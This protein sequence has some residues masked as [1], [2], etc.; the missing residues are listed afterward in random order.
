MPLNRDAYGLRFSFS[1]IF[2]FN[3]NSKRCHWSFNFG[4]RRERICKRGKNSENNCAEINF[5]RSYNA[6]CI[7]W[8]LC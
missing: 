4:G 2:M 6:L 1:S 3:L 7:V 8:G 5:K